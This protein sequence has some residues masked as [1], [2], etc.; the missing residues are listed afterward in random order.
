MTSSV[1]TKMN[2]P[3]KINVGFQERRDTYT[4]KLAYVVYTDHKG[5][6]RKQQSWEGW[7]DKK[8]P[9]LEFDNVPTSGFVLNKKVGGTKYGW[10]P[11]ATY[12]RIYD[13]RDFEFEITVANLLFILQEAT[14]TKGKGLEGEF[15]YA[16]DGKDLVL[17]PVDCDEYRACSDFTSKQ[18]K[19]VNKTEIKPGHTY[20]MK[21]MTK[22]MYLGK[23]PHCEKKGWGKNIQYVPD[24][25]H[26]IF[27]NID[28]V[29]PEHSWV[30]TSRYIPLSGYTKLAEVISTDTAGFADRFTAY[31][32]SPYYK[33]PTGIEINQKKV[34]L[35]N[36][37]GDHGY[38][39]QVH[40]I[41]IDDNNNLHPVIITKHEDRVY[42]YGSNT[43]V[44]SS[45]R[46][47]TYTGPAASFEYNGVGCTLP[48]FNTWS[49]RPNNNW[50]YHNS[51]DGGV[52]VS[53]Q[54]LLSME[55]YTVELVSNHGREDLLING[56]R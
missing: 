16:W 21:D 20:L 37:E 9:P 45:V 55:L 34:E 50:N 48:Q 19:K 31:K 51:G 28:Y 1:S 42:D 49:L 27:E 12:V 10:N 25:E 43:Y 53:E 47:T 24:G 22:V 26:H 4:Q 18:T 46:Y 3:T 29:E 39:Q 54:D 17:L 11:R 35:T 13:P 33:I 52:I 36:F 44:V 41:S 5:V 2:I 8:I 32:R 40:R 30:R 7:R 56:F 14:S 23:L 38:A 15:V 6:V